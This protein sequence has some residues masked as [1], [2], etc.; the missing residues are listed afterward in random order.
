[1]A[2]FKEWTSRLWA[3]LDHVVAELEDHDALVESSLRTLGQR[4]EK[5]RLELE[6][7]R[8]DGTRLRSQLALEQRNVETWREA[9]ACEETDAEALRLLRRAR[10]ARARE[11]RLA[12]Q[13][14]EHTDAEARFGERA[15]ALTER[16]D[17]LKRRQHLMRTRTAEVVA[18]DAEPLELAPIE[19]VFERWDVSLTRAEHL[20]DPFGELERQEEERSLLVELAE[21]RRGA[22]E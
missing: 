18:R 1:M 12:Q 3:G 21:L 13:L 9:A 19:E 16:I 2:F 15:A 20:A 11:R 22:P 17:A 8:A 7:A 6:R 4:A 5:T 14:K 10:R